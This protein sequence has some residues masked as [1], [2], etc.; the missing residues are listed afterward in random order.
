[1]R[2]RRR[3]PPWWV[4]AEHTYSLEA[5]RDIYIH[6]QQ[7]TE[8]ISSTLV[9][10]ALSGEAVAD[11]IPTEERE[12]VIKNVACTSYAGGVDTVSPMSESPSCTSFSR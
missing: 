3:L 4:L 9:G 12:Q 10:A 11:D 5:F 2:R 8:G 6:G 1:M 7:N